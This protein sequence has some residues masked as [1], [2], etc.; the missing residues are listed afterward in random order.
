MNYKAVLVGAFAAFAAAA[1]SAQDFPNKPIT[2]VVPFAAGGGADVQTRIIAAGMSKDLGQPVIIENRPGATGNVGLDS[3]AAAPPDGYRILSL[4]NITVISRNLQNLPFDLPKMMTPIGNFLLTPTNLVVNSAKVPATNL[5]E[6]VAWVQ[7]RKGTTFSSA[8]NG[9]GGHLTMSLFKSTR[10]LDM[11]HVGYRG[12]A[13]ALAALVTGEIDMMVIDGASFAPQADAKEVRVIAGASSKRNG[14]QPKIPTATEQG[15]PE[16]SFDPVL[17]LSAPPGT[18]MPVIERLAKAMRIAANAE[19]F[20]SLVGKVGN[21]VHFLDSAQFGA[22]LADDYV[23][24]GKV[25]RD[26]N[27]KAE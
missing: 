17:G 21:T 20:T 15:F 14:V 11:T 19:E 27:I 16:V 23:K 7:S 12:A 24:W 25:I 18:P 10:N 4:S 26:N 8:G 1:A 9:D 22:M 13:P 5:K 6:L 2:I 3:V